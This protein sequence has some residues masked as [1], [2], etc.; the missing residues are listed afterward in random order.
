MRLIRLFGLVVG[1]ALVAS[2]AS[3]QAPT[4]YQ[5]NYYNVGAPS[6][7]Q[8]ETFA[9]SSA[10]CNQAPIS[11]ASSVNPS[12]VVLNDT[13]NAGKICVI[14]DPAG[15]MLVSLPIGATGSNYEGT[16]V[17]IN[18]VGASAESARAPF[19]R[20]AAPPAP[21]GVLFVR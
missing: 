8:S 1:C 5:A 10:I 7:L 16:L 3:A 18:A 19:S 15:G 11:G 6:P 21:T 17:A 13:A 12:R 2:V 20:G 14:A 4:S 9:A